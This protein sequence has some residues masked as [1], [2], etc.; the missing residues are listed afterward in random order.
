[1]KTLKFMPSACGYAYYQSLGVARANHLTQLVGNLF[2]LLRIQLTYFP[3]DISEQ[4]KLS[5]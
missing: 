4:H 1:M 2:D 5:Q 3:D